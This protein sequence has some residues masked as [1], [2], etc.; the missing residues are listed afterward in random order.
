MKR[1]IVHADIVE[2]T[3]DVLIYSTNTRL[4][5]TGGVASALLG[6]F[7]IG[8][9]IVLHGESLGTGRQMAEVGDVF[10]TSIVGSPW[11]NVFHTIATD[12]IYHTEEDAVRSILRACFRKCAASSDLQ[13]IVCSALGTGYGD[14]DLATFLTIAHQVCDEFDRSGIVS[15]SVVVR[16]SDEFKTLCDAGTRIGSW[17]H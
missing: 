15:F 2:V 7:G 9:Q 10:V 5:L 17:I 12:E 1:K 8:V 14:L 16:E 3:A 11:K 4:A 6:K 13:T